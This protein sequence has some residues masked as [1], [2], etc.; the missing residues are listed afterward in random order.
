MRQSLRRRWEANAPTVRAPP[1]PAPPRQSRGDALTTG[2]APTSPPPA[3]ASSPT[4]S[5]TR[6]TSASTNISTIWP[7]TSVCRQRM[8]QQRPG[9]T[10]PQARGGG[11]HLPPARPR[12]EG[13]DTES[14]AVQPVDRADPGVCR[15]PVRVDQRPAEQP[16]GVLSRSVAQR[17]GLCVVGDGVQFLPKFQHETGTRR[18]PFAMSGEIPCADGGKNRLEKLK[19]RENEG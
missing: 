10:A 8:P 14:K 13:T 2:T 12:A 15:A 17:H 5:T 1:I 11:G 18:W 16:P 6:P 9:G 7:A 3:M 4:M 19:S